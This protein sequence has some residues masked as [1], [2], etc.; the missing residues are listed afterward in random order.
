MTRSPASSTGP[1]PRRR[2]EHSAHGVGQAVDRN[3]HEGSVGAVEGIAEV[4]VGAVDGATGE[5]R[6]GPRVDAPHRGPEATAG[7]Q[8]NGAADEP[9]ADD[10]DDQAPTKAALPATAAAAC[11][12]AA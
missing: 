1:R 2:S 7:G 12:R 5:G 8:A 3:G 10:R 11:T 6:V 9:D 4:A